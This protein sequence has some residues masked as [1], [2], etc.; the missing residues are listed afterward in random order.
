[1]PTSNLGEPSTSS[2]AP[3]PGQRSFARLGSCVA[4][5]NSPAAPNPIGRPGSLVG[6]RLPRERPRAHLAPRPTTTEGPP[7]PPPLQSLVSFP[8]GE[9][10]AHAWGRNTGRWGNIQDRLVA[11][12][13]SRFLDG[14]IL[15]CGCSTLR[16]ICS[17]SKLVLRRGVDGIVV[18][19]EAR[20]AFRIELWRH[21]DSE[22]GRC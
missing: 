9:R 20:L 8:L 1:M 15:S 16:W 3:H 4:R 17:A 2:E 7:P 6:S 12:F 10:Y 19:E 5:P 18:G 14:A 21:G 22:Q 11:Y 13:L